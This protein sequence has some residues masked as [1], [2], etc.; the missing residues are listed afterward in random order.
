MRGVRAQRALQMTLVVTAVLALLGAGDDTGRRFSDLGHKLMCRCGCN[1]V[2]LECNHVGCEYSDRMRGEL[3]TA[4]DRGD[5]DQVV[6]AAFV[7]KYGT[8]VLAAPTTKGFN[9]VAWI[10]PFIALALGTV[11]AAWVMR[12][13]Q[14]RQK[15]AA[16]VVKSRLSAAELEGLRR[17]AREETEI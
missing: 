13:W 6:L 3:K 8:T 2:L 15:P 7:E 17:Q 5:S 10:M 1:Q 4:I 12:L 9:L 14:R 16:A 11:L